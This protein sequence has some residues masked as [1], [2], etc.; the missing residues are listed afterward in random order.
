[1]DSS[2]TSHICNNRNLF[3]DFTPS[4]QHLVGI[5]AN[6]L[7]VLGSG[8]ISLMAPDGHSLTLNDVLFVPEFRKCLVSISWVVRNNRSL[9]LITGLDG[10]FDFDSGRRYTFPIGV[11][12]YLLDYRPIPA[13]TPAFSVF[14][15]VPAIDNHA[16][17]GHA[18]P[19]ILKK[20]GK[21]TGASV[22]SACMIGHSVKS[23]GS[24]STSSTHAPLQ[25]IHADVSEE[26][27]ADAVLAAEFYVNR[28]PSSAIDFKVP[29]FRWYGNTPD[30]SLFHPSGF[31][32]HAL[33]PP[34]KWVSKFSSTAIPASSVG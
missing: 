27:W 34:E 25:L 22:C 32:F 9:K 6:S 19:A 21:D 14:T 7:S 11:S 26:L 20:I 4:S 15:S 30:Y 12:L 17:Y 24:N 8:S 31:S 28:L 23:Y 2:A 13:S 3:T 10:I 1:M 33:I 29:Y 16:L 5:D 18:P